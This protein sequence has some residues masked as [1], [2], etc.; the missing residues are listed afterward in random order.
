[1]PIQDGVVS[2]CAATR[3][4]TWLEGADSLL[5]A[6]SAFGPYVII[7]QLGRGGMASVYKAYEAGLD[8][9]VALKVLPAEFITEATMEE[10]F[11]REAK[12][13]AR[14]EHPNI[15]PIF[16]YGI[17]S[18]A[19]IPWMAMRLIAG[20]TL[21][22]LI[23]ERQL[24][25]AEIVSIVRAVAEALDYAHGKG[26]VH[27]DVKPQNVL[28]DESG[29]LYLA[30]FGIARMVEGASALTQTGMISGTPHY[31]APE[32]AMSGTVD[33]RCDIYALGVIAYQ[34]L[35]GRVPFTADTP[36]AVLMKQV[37]DP[38]PLPSPGEVPEP[39]MRAILKSM[40]K[41]PEDRWRSAGEFARALE[42]GSRDAAPAPAVSPPTI[43]MPTPGPTRGTSPTAVTPVAVSRQSG[44]PTASAASARSKAGVIALM[45]A[46][47][48]V[49]I[50]GTAVLLRRASAPGAAQLTPSPVAQSTGPAV[51]K[52]QPP[53]PSQEAAPSAEPTPGAE[54]TP[55]R[56]PASQAPRITRTRPAAPTSPPTPSEPRAAP[57]S[58]SGPLPSE[59]LAPS[60]SIDVEVV[61]NPRELFD[62]IF[63]RFDLDERTAREIALVFSG[64]SR[65]EKRERVSIDGISQGPHKLLVMV[66]S[67]QSMSSSDLVQA[68]KPLTVTE[69]VNR[70]SVQVHLVDSDNSTI[71]FR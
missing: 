38:I 59:A 46:A 30:D 55:L 1:V 18:N 29:R 27:R 7:E 33:H 53:L 44:P 67:S 58:A 9:Y 54:P 57:V 62:T 35:T 49:V 15:V 68:V 31:M 16:G 2:S 37:R 11:Q 28:L 47:L 51:V 5:I 45:A 36:V 19:H 43:Q 63:V 25:H 10:R 39:T 23:K 41:K 32:Q 20:G 71:R 14:L 70:L 4:T 64:A 60:L 21:S 13:I 26:V 34:M 56:G 61:Q 48:V 66:S 17:D 12:V 40:A 24:S 3:L 42:Q 50:A 52:S 22:A 6:G 69:G 65:T 8:R